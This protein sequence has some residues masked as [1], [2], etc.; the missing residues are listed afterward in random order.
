[1][2]TEEVVSGTEV[3]GE[4]GNEKE[5]LCLFGSCISFYISYHFVEY[6]PLS[7]NDD[8]VEGSIMPLHILL[9]V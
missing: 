4:E 6:V 9:I 3:N 8:I 1:M 7:G 2:S 5:R